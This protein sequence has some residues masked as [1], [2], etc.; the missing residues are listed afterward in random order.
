MWVWWAYL[1]RYVVLY[2]MPSQFS[3]S[4]TSYMVCFFTL[5][6]VCILAELVAF[7]VVWLELERRGIF[8]VAANEGF[9]G[10]RRTKLLVAF[11]SSDLFS[12]ILVSI[13]S[14]TGF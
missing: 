2:E 9:V 10:C 7:L 14:F 6:F 4:S 1:E 8:A 13:R 5:L 3:Y 11:Q 12:S